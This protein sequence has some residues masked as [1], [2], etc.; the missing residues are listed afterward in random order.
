MRTTR[1]RRLAIVATLSLTA[2][3]GLAPYASAHSGGAS[4]QGAAGQKC[5]TLASTKTSASSYSNSSKSLTVASGQTVTITQTTHLKGLTIKDGGVLTAPAGYALTLTVNGVETGQKVKAT[6]A[7]ES[8]LSAGSWKGDIVLT[9]AEDN[10]VTFNNLVYKFRQAL[11][12]GENGV[13]KA[14]GVSA[15]VSGK[16]TDDAAKNVAITSTGELFN[17][18]YVKDREYTI[19]NPTISLTGNGR[20]DFAGQGAGIIGTGQATDLVVDGAKISNKGA[21]RP[22]VI[23][24]DGAN[25][26]VKNSQIATADGT[27][28]SDYI[29][30]VN[31][32]YMQDA[33]WMLGISGNNRSTNVL[34]SNTQATYVSS[35]ISSQN[36]G[37]LSVDTGSNMKLNAIN[38]VVCNTGKDGYGSYVIGNATEHFLGTKFHVKTFATIVTGGKVVYGDSTKA[39]VTELNE[40]QNLGLTA[41]E[42]AK[43]GKRNTLVDSDRFGIMWH[44]QGDVDISGKTIF[45]TDETTFLDKG[46]QVNVTVDG[47]KGAQLNP[48]NGVLLQ[49][50]QNDDP[51][52]VPPSMANTGVY[53]EPTS[54]PSKDASF[55]V[56]AEHDADAEAS[57][58]DITLT[59]SFYNAMRNGKNMVL[60]FDDTK[61]TGVISSSTAKHRVSTITS[62]NYRELGT[63]TNTPSA[64][65]NNGTIVTLSNGA[66][67]TV[68]GTSHLTSLTVGSDA[69]VKAAGKKKVSMTVDG[70]ATKI[71]AGKT[72]TGGIV[73]TVG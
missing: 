60:N 41:K 71:E 28:P 40:S 61:V 35:S 64:A 7:T 32:S 56:S 63:V 4:Q 16:V 49:V 30:S 45:N 52:P 69:T 8:V 54:A 67:W 20:S 29:S 68:T 47:S 44:N 23:A 27:L 10:L 19:T 9:V 24:D 53:T 66:Q 70:V 15:A 57:F 17:G 2:V 43:L 11:F 14:K 33:P 36:W 38:S 18:I 73:L 48:G 3:T 25:V 72:Y 51:G 37:A 59:G 21:V 12:V 1:T 46:Q 65:V 34:G 6:G 5:A 22:A 55:D 13:E 31:L 39:A 50:M 62:A 26:V 58:N 42:I